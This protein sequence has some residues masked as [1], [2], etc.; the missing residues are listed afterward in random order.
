MLLMSGCALLFS[1]RAWQAGPGHLTPESSTAL[2]LG[3]FPTAPPGVITTVLGP[4]LHCVLLVVLFS[5][6]LIAKV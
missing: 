2:P 5:S 1:G 6:L 3:G 4:T